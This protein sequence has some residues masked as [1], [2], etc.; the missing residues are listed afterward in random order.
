MV[1]FAMQL[2]SVVIHNGNLF[3]LSKP[4]IRDEADGI[5]SKGTAFSENAVCI[6]MD[7]L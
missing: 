3:Q 5:F 1:V 2:I 7:W 4:R 6:C